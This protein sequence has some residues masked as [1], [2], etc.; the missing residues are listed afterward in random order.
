[1]VPKVP[2]KALRYLKYLRYLRYLRYLMQAKGKR[3]M[4]FEAEILPV[5][6]GFCDF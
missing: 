6:G 2:V 3:K 1:M 4:G 5:C